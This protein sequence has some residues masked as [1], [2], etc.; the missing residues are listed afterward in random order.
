[1]LFEKKAHKRTLSGIA[2]GY[3]FHRDALR[4]R[5]RISQVMILP[6]FR[7]QGMG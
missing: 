2:T 1:M 3:Q 4:Y 5:A 6:D 7:G